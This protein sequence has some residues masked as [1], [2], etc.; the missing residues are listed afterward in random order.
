MLKNSSAELNLA[1]NSARVNKT[2]AKQGVV[3]IEDNSGL[4]IFG[5][6][7]RSKP[8]FFIGQLAHEVFS[9]PVIC[10][11]F[12]NIIKVEPIFLLRRLLLHLITVCNCRLHL[13]ALRQDE[14]KYIFLLF[15]HLTRC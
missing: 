1:V 10:S 4:V 15:K 7:L 3:P 12:G 13:L 9:Q 5:L 14:I 11:V 8:N 6:L 2:R